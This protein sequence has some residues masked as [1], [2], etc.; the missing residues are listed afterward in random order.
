MKWFKHDSDANQD[1]KLRRLRMKYGMEGYGLYWYCLEMIAR[2]VEESRLTFELE[3]DS[4]L[5]AVDTGIHY[6]RVQDMMG[7]MVDLGLF[8]QAS[9]VITCLKMAHRTDEYTAR[10]IAKSVKSGRV[11]PLKK[12]NV[13]TLSG[14]CPDNVPTPSRECPALLEEKRREESNRGRFAPPTPTQVSEYAAKAGIT[15]DADRFVDFY[16]SK[17]WKV[18]KTPMKDWQ[19]A[20]RN[21]K[22]N[23]DHQKTSPSADDWKS[24][25][26]V[27]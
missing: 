8:E 14:A 15:I 23:A 16:A 24:Q 6:E 7:Y 27:L 9:G 10:L 19:A 12:D 21:W 1:A 18:G 2:G 26:V 11:L 25:G 20:V 17:G 22:R 3:H 5:I 13:P 4:E